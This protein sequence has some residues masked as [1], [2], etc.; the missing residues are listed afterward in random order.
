M[1]D[2]HVEL[3]DRQAKDEIGAR[4]DENAEQESCEEKAPTLISA[5][6]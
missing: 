5:P 4:S 2:A 3:E 6:M 1:I